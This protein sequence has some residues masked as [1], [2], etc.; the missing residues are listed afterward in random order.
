VRKEILKTFTSPLRKRGRLEGVLKVTRLRGSESSTTY[1][2]VVPHATYSPWWGDEE[3]QSVWTQVRDNTLVDIYRLYELWNLVGQV[4]DLEG[5]ILEVGVW[6]GGSGSLIASRARRDGAT[7]TVYMCDTFAGVVKAGAHDANY[8]GGELA[9]TSR[10]TVEALVK[11]LGLTNVEIREGIF[12]D[13]TGDSVMVDKLRFCHIDVDVYESALG[14]FEWA[15]PKLVSGG[16]VVFDDYGF[17]EQEGV[18]NFA[19]EISTCSDL[20]FVHNLN[21]HAVA[22]K[23]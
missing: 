15:W 22:I 6:R 9:D 16:I 23:R 10:A 2:V 5:D 17:Y 13:E 18:T 8:D 20:T 4:R 7:A 3:F 1:Q 19:N 14:V 21:G 11:R 12:P